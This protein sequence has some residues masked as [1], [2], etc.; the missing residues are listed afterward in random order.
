MTGNTDYDTSELRRVF[1]S[2]FTWAAAFE[3][4]THRYAQRPALSDPP[5]G[6]SWT[7][8]Q[9]GA[10]TGRLV[11]GLRDRGVGVG[12]IICYQLKN[13]PEFAMLYI[14]AQG[15]RAVSSPMNFRLAPAET[16]HIL[17]QTRPVVFV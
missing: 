3:R 6:R 12:D 14:A 16:A 2:R 4:N 5:S 1:E 10:D 15:L 13:T 11:A 7:Y 8:A 9:L 17:D